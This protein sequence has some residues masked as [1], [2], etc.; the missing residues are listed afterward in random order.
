MPASTSTARCFDRFCWLVPSCSASAVTLTSRSRSRSSA[1][2]RSGSPSARNRRAIKSAS[3]SGIGRGS[4]ICIVIILQNYQVV[5]LCT[6]LREPDLEE[7]SLAVVEAPI[8]VPVAEHPRAVGPVG[9]LGGWAAAHIRLVSLTWVAI[10]IALGI[11]APKVET[12]LSGAGWQA[13]GSQSVQARTLI[14]QDFG[15]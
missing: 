15:G 10:A 6:M 14:Q 13:S 8:A 12:A 9:R 1:R 11:F 3:S 4:V 2:T 5:K 7:E